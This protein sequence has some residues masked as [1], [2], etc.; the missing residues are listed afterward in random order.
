VRVQAAGRPSA[1]RVL[2]FV[3]GVS[4]LASVFSG[5]LAWCSTQAA[6][7]L[8]LRGPMPLPAGDAAHAMWRLLL[9][10]GW[11]APSRAFPTAAERAAAPA[12]WAYGALAICF[13]ALLGRAGWCVHRRVRAWRA[14]SP[15]GKGQRTIARHAVDQ[16]WVH[17]RT[18]AIPSDMV[19][20]GSRVRVPTSAWRESGI[21]KRFSAPCRFCPSTEPPRKRPWEVAE[22][23]PSAP[24]FRG[25]LQHA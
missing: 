13:L 16:G 17:Q 10:G 2:A 25:G 18:W 7:V 24:G 4:V 8:E 20:R 6:R 9:R 23:A 5:A 22:N 11:S 3:A 21:T 14:G 15:L 19:R 12:A 1:T